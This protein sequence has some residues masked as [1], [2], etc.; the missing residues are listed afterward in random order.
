MVP[1][2]TNVLI[3]MSWV[4]NGTKN[5]YWPGKPETG[6]PFINTPEK[7]TSNSK[8]LLAGEPA[9]LSGGHATLASVP[10]PRLSVTVPFC[11][12]PEL[13]DS[14]PPK[15]PEHEEKAKEK[16]RIKR[17]QSVFEKFLLIY[18]MYII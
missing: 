10:P 17:E 15:I 5:V 8:S 18:N 1:G 6:V 13:P 3:S 16:R 14:F 12:P 2:L 9:P 4:P 11:E 7:R